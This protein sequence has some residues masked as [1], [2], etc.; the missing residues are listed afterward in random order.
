MPG[1]GGGLKGHDKGSSGECKV[2]KKEA[3]APRVTIETK[4][5]PEPAPSS[6]ADALLEEAGTA[7]AKHATQTVLHCCIH[8]GLRLLHPFMPFVTEELYQRLQILAG[9]PRSTIMLAPYPEPR[10]CAMWT[11]P[12]AE[13]AMAMISSMWP[14]SDGSTSIICT[15]VTTFCPYS[16]VTTLCCRSSPEP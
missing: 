9:E 10:S 16:L 14:W 11:S 3:E 12:R 7:A 5:E 2:V 8:N 13:A 1:G 6:D 15:L 4:R